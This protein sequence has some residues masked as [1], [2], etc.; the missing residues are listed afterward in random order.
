[1]RLDPIGV[2]EACYRPVRGDREWL[3]GVLAALEPVSHGYGL[4]AVAYDRIRQ[5]VS[6]EAAWRPH[7]WIEEAGRATVEAAPAT[8]R[9][10]YAPS[11]PVDLAFRRLRRAGMT[12]SSAATIGRVQR[13][14]VGDTLGIF[15][16]EP[17]GRGLLVGIP[18]RAGSRPS[19]R[20]VHQL[21]CIAAHLTS[22]RRLRELT[23][24][25]SGEAVLDPSGR[26]Q[27]ATGAATL[28]DARHALTL[29]VRDREHARGRLRKADPIAAAEIWKGLVDGRWSLVETIESDGRRLVLARRNDPSVP[30]PKAL[31]PAERTVAAYAALG[32]SNKY[33]AYLLG[34]Q[35]STVATHLKSA[36]RKLGLGSRRELIGLLGTPPAP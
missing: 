30:D 13:N 14:G 21:S 19:P 20:V 16:G 11:P 8:F 35:P 7:A 17:D 27:H 1:V 22:A 26:I 2:I 3:E 32:H 36:Q 28:R 24:A 12:D 23:A 15:T 5:A 25:E 34:L 4:Y 10:L 6:L 33:I 18:Q 31:R 9:A 29:A